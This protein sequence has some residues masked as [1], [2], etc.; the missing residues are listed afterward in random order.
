ML[1]SLKY[2]VFQHDV[3][4]R[5]FHIWLATKHKNSLNHSLKTAFMNVMNAKRKWRAV[6]FTYNWARTCPYLLCFSKKLS[7]FSEVSTASL[8]VWLVW[9]FKL[10][11][12]SFLFGFII[13][14]HGK[15]TLSAKILYHY[16]E[17]IM[18]DHSGK[19]ETSPTK[20]S[21]S[22]TRAILS[23]LWLSW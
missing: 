18:A 4:V 21:L 15:Y 5:R 1:F 19:K 9:I 13:H 22:T 8:N 12:A 20:V 2:S 7:R 16:L 23:T 17:V 10:I 14:S 11:S 6:V 3:S